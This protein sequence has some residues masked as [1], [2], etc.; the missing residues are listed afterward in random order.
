M[1]Y[2]GTTAA[3]S[4]SNPPRVLLPATG[5]ALAANSTSMGKRGGQVWYYCSSDGTTVWQ[6]TAYFTDG[7]QLGMQLGDLLMGVSF[8]TESSTGHISV[9]GALVTTNSTAG[10]NLSTGGAMTSTFS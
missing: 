3:S 10:W 6:N 2:N 5:L 7:K 4:V 1:A 9:L 8:S